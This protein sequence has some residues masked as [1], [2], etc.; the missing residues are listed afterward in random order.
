MLHKTTSLL[1]L[2]AKSQ[3]NPI[4]S[5]KRKASVI[6]LVEE[7]VRP[8]FSSSLPPLAKPVAHA[9]FKRSGL[10][11]MKGKHAAHRLQRRLK[12]L[13]SKGSIR[14][15]KGGTLLQPLKKPK[16][17]YPRST[18]ISPTSTSK[19]SLVW[20]RDS[21]DSFAKVIED[22]VDQMYRRSIRLQE[23]IR[24][25]ELPKYFQE[26]HRLE[27]QISSDTKHFLNSAI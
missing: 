15:L 17:Q 27:S 14:V 9:I 26:L 25:T 18:L 23:L 13:Q 2:P 19:G 4:D 24:Q 20:C 6:G 5:S 8:F 1:N 16:S 21:S 3:I 22:R 12:P 10:A 7:A 11:V